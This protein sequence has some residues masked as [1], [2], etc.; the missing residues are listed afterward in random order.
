MLARRWEFYFVSEVLADY[1]VHNSNHH[2]KIARD[3]TEERSVTWL[4]DRV[5]GEREGDSV[6]EQA[7]QKARSDV[8]AAQFM[9]FAAKYFSHGDNKNSRRCY[10]AAIRYDS[11]LMF[12]AKVLQHLI[13]SFIPRS[14]YERTKRVLQSA[15]N[16]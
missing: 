3:G 2:T 7:K 6:L 16:A 15:R 13:A 12:S 9:D 11:G 10:L 4:L 5:F 8:Y 14:L 1:R